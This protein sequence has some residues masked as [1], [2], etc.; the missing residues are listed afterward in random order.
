MISSYYLAITYAGY[1]MDWK[2]WLIAIIAAALLIM[3][4]GGSIISSTGHSAKTATNGSILE[5]PSAVVEK[6]GNNLKDA[7]ITTVLFIVGVA[8]LVLYYRYKS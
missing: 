7:A 3:Y 4:V 2:S 6:A 1:R 8:S 5:Q